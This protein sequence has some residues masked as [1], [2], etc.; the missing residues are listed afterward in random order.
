MRHVRIWVAMLLTV[1]LTA[2]CAD[3]PTAPQAGR[4]NPTGPSYD[5]TVQGCV[6]DG[7]CVLPPISGGGCDPWEDLNWC[8]DD[9]GQCMTS[10]PGTGDPEFVGIAGCPGTGPGGPGGGGTQ[11]PPSEPPP[12]TEPGDTCNTGDAVVDDPQVSDG[13]QDLWARSNP[14]ANLAQRR[15]TAG[16]IVEYPAGQFSIVPITTTSASFGCADFTVQFP[17]TG[18]VVGFV[19]THPYQVDETIIDC[20]LTSVQDYTGAPSDEDRVASKLLGNALGRSDPLPGYIIDKDGYYRF[21]GTRYTATPRLPR[22][23]Y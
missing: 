5:Q 20:D 14:D 6:S 13:L 16:W 21:E 7:Y 22:C 10:Q 17:T 23:G 4:I 1:V 2:A 9:G 19:H 18:T 12:P 15:E 11:P 3:A 8:E